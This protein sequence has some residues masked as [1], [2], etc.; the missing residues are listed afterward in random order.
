M[1]D[2]LF[3]AY[4]TDDVELVKT[5]TLQLE[6]MIGDSPWNYLLVVRV[7]KD[8]NQLDLARGFLEK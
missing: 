3:L 7:L 5:L 4:F 6:R 2:Y 8:T 1:T